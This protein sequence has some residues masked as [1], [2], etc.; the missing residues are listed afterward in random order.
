[1]TGPRKRNVRWGLL[2]LLFLLLALVCI[3]VSGRQG[4]YNAVTLAGVVVG[5]LGAGYCSFRGLKGFS[6]LPR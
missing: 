2:S 1:M 3:L 5:F 4:S 6:W